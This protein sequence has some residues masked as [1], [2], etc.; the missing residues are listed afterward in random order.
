MKQTM[1]RVRH[2]VPGL[3]LCALV[4]FSLEVAADDQGPCP[5]QR[6]ESKKVCIGDTYYTCKCP[7]REFTSLTMCPPGCHPTQQNQVK[8]RLEACQVALAVTP[9]PPACVPIHL[10]EQSG[11]GHDTNLSDNNTCCTGIKIR[12]C[13]EIPPDWPAA[14]SDTS[15]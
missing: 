15:S 6:T 2:L 13:R 10:C 5:D 14:A 1:Q 7:E 9:E 12:K 8:N 11:S 3:V 4:G